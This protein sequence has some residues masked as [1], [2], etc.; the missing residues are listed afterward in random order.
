MTTPVAGTGPAATGELDASLMAE[1][2]AA[3]ERVRGRTSPN[4]W[5]GAV[6]VAGPGTPTRRDRAGTPAERFVGATSPPGG[7]HAEVEALARA[8]SRARGGTLVVTLEPCAHHGRTPPCTDAIVAAGVRR[9]VVGMV[10]PDPLVAGK[11][12]DALR[13]AGVEVDVG[14]GAEEVAQQLAP[15]VK[16]R[17]TGRPWVVLKL[18]ATLDGRVAAPDG[19]SRWITG[20]EARADAHRLRATSDAVLVGAGTVRLDDPALTVR[21]PVDDPFHRDAA[22][23]PRRVVLGHAPEG[24]AVLPAIEVS[25]DLGDVLDRL[26]AEGVLQLLVEGGAGVAGAFHRQGLVDAYV[27]YL[28]PVLLG[29]DDGRAL[30]AGRGAAT[31]ADAWRGTVRS[32]TTLGPDIRVVVTPAG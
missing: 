29:G 13:A 24:A 5:V 20:P 15:Y 25:G 14:T 27:V 9:V 12:V 16:H 11:G 17:L 31:I 22:S 18:A 21:L 30:F 23:Q 1:A 7:P 32:V 8:G 6:V 28:A 26:G 19:S 3:A 2:L 10:D 4:P